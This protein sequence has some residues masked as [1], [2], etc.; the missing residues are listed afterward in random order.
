M[1]GPQLAQVALIADDDEYFRIALSAILRQLGFVEIIEA[2]SFDE[3]LERLETAGSVDLAI[4]DLS[5]PGI[6]D[7]VALRT[8]RASFPVRRLAV[9]SAST[10]RSDILTSLDAGAHGFVH[11]GDGVHQLKAALRQ[12]VDGAIYIPA[13]LADLDRASGEGSTPSEPATPVRRKSRLTPRQWEVAEKLVQGKSNKEIA[14]ELD[15]GPGTVKVHLAALFR[16]LGVSNRASAAV[17]GAELFRDKSGKQ[18]EG[19]P[20]RDRSVPH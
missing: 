17:A 2:A 14:R 10:Q 11:K 4:F 16:A 19:R 12:I 13:S 6:D 7:P 18:G 15:L 20:D 3:A 9:V 8:V 1:D 5:M